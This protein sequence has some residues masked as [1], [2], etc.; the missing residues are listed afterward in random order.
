MYQW[1]LLS[2]YLILC[3]SARIYISWAMVVSNDFAEAAAYGLCVLYIFGSG[4]SKLMIGRRTSYFKTSQRWNFIDFNWRC[5]WIWYGSI[6]DS[7]VTDATRWF[8]S[9][10]P[11]W[12]FAF[13]STDLCKEDAQGGRCL[14]QKIGQHDGQQEVSIWSFTFSWVCLRWSEIFSHHNLGWLLIFSRCLEQIQ[15]LK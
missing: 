5:W 14:G 13:H 15:V 11:S 3:I 4:L 7:Y 8:F 10:G 1:C 2:A 9:M 12:N 6:I